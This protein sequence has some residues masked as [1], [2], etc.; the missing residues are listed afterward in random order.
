MPPDLPS[1]PA[2]GS[3][4]PAASDETAAAVRAERQRIARV[5]HDTVAQTLTGTYF[6]ATI[7]TRKLQQ[8]GSEAAEDVAHLTELIQRAVGEL[9][10]VARM[11]TSEERPARE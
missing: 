3:E 2:N 6:H 1:G 10:E 5:L 8:S 11:L 7:T 9:Q 4:R